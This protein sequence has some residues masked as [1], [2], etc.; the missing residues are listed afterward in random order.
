MSLLHS[1]IQSIFDRN[2]LGAV[3][4][5]DEHPI[6]FNNKIIFVNNKYVLKIV[7][8]A[9]IEDKVRKEGLLLEIFRNKLPIA[10]IIVSDFSKTVI[11]YS[12][13]LVTRIE[14]INLY[15]VWAQLSD[16]ERETIV[17]EIIECLRILNVSF[18]QI[19]R[20]MLKLTKKQ[21]ISRAE[22]VEWPTA[23][24]L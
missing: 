3:T 14:G 24:G 15:Q 20:K 17:R 6:G 11:P 7:T 13:L 5:V 19:E 4:K 9:K 16:N 2:N 18:V 8:N 23:W 1:Q 22:P 10:N 21:Q 12:Y